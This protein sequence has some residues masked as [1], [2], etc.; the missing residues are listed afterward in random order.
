[1]SGPLA[2]MWINWNLSRTESFRAEAQVEK[3]GVAL[4]EVAA[5]TDQTSRELK[6]K[7]KE[8]KSRPVSA[9]EPFVESPTPFEHS[10]PAA[11]MLNF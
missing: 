10:L 7:L 5:D 9:R 4:H 8:A 11:A 6:Q 3:A 1:M 2:N